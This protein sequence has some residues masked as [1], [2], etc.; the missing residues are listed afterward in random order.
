VFESQS[1]LD[2]Q[3]DHLGF[4]LEGQG[5]VVEGAVAGILHDDEEVVAA[6]ERR[7]IAYYVG[8]IEATM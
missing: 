8:V 3:V 1:Q 2:Y 7:V 4:C 5:Q 6:S